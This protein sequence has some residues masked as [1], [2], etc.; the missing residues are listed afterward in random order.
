MKHVPFSLIRRQFLLQ[1]LVR[2]AAQIRY[3]LAKD[4]LR[5]VGVFRAKILGV[6]N[7]SLQGIVASQGQDRKVREG[8][9]LV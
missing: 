6:V 9:C 8:S 3:R 1:G 7:H 4:F 2:R 5:E